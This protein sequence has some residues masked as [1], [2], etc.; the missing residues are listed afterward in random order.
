[1]GRRSGLSRFRK[2]SCRSGASRP[3]WRSLIG[4]GVFACWQRS[5]RVGLECRNARTAE[6]RAAKRETPARRPFRASRRRW[7]AR[8]PSCESGSAA[9][10]P[11]GGCGSSQMMESRGGA[12]RDRRVFEACRVS[13]V[14][15][16]VAS[17][18]PFPPFRS[19]T[20]VQQSRTTRPLRFDTRHETGDFAVLVRD[21]AVLVARL[22]PLAQL[23]HAP[24]TARPLA[25]ASRNPRTPCGDD[26]VRL[27]CGSAVASRASAL[28]ATPHRPL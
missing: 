22:E 28:P 6:V 19:A 10:G 2:G 27:C 1:M 20:W 21:D 14:G 12:V 26:T 18:E 24:A 25:E 3:P 23:A 16:S 17:I 8:L 9:V 7:P 4:T 13:I 11:A 15:L 5:W